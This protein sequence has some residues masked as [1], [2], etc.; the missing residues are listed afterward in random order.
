MLSRPVSAMTSDV[1]L[2]VRFARA[3]APRSRLLLAEHPNALAKASVL[4]NFAADFRALVVARG[5]TSLTFAADESYTAS[6][7]TRVLTLTPATG[8][9]GEKTGWKDRLSR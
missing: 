2:R 3:V 5:L 1:R 4:S 8:V 9:L 6:V 7:A